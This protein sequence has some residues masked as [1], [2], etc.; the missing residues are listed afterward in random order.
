MSSD[1]KCSSCGIPIG[2]EQS[3]GFKC[4]SCG[5]TLIGRCKNCRDQSA[6]YVCAEC[7]FEGP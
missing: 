2:D 3:V 6:I 1:G 4:P 7:G 5:K